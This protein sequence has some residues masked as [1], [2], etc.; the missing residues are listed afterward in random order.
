MTALKHGMAGLKHGMAALGAK[1]SRASIVLVVFPDQLSWQL[2]H[3]SKVVKQGVQAI[4]S[5]QAMQ[6][7]LINALKQTDASACRV[8]VRLSS[9]FMRFAIVGN[10]DGARSQDELALISRHAFERVHGEIVATWDIRL[11]YGAIGQSGL[12]SAVDQ[13]LLEKLKST[14]ESAGYQ[15]GKVEPTLMQAFNRLAPSG[16]H[17]IFA[18]KEAGRLALLAWQQGG[19]VAVQLQPLSTD[20][21]AQV[22]DSLARLKLQLG[23]AEDTPL[24]I[25]SMAANELEA[26]ALPAPRNIGLA[27][28]VAA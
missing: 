17:G 20:W 4:T 5:P 9:H 10:P 22:Q 11:S 24:Q 28:Q 25:A 27:S 14:L 6:Q 7:A 1:A 23:L 8:D 15:L 19:W 3:G 26:L 21:Q 2:K 16:P 13:A 12:A 18:L